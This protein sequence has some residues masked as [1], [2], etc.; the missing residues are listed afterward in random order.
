MSAP[1]TVIELLYADVT[2]KA[3]SISLTTVFGPSYESGIK[4][5]ESVI[6]KQGGDVASFRASV[7]RVLAATD[8]DQL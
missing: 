5:A 6:E 1:P 4:F 2:A 8:P 7:E 3:K